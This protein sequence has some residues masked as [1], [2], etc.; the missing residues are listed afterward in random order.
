[1]RSGVLKFPRVVADGPNVFIDP[2]GYRSYVVEKEA[3]FLKEWER[4]KR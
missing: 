3:A 1:M 2:E 4:Q